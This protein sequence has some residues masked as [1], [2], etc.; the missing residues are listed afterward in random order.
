M[1]VYPDYYKDFKCINKKC[2][3]NCCIGWEIDIDP[4]TFSFYNSVKGELGQRLKDNID[5]TDQPHFI[6]G[7]NERC[8]FLN[9]S[10]LCDIIT[11]LGEGCI[12]DI[13]RE[14]PRFYNEFGDTTESGLGLCCEEAARIILTKRDKVSLIF[15]GKSGFYD[16]QT[17]IRDRII[18]ILQNREKDIDKRFEEVYEFLNIKA[19]QFQISDWLD[20][21]LRLER[22]DDKWTEI[23]LLLKENTEKVDLIKFENY[24]FDRKT[25]YEQ[26]V[27]YLIYR[28]FLIY[29]GITTVLFADFVYQLIFLIG[30]VFYA[31]DG[32]YSQET[33]IEII[34]M[35]SSEIEYS[36]ENL[37]IIYSK[38]W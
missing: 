15:E 7:A 32:E 31:A 29:D 23:L 38:L 14:H 30:A 19:P 16:N 37:G 3:H 6:L 11:D 2:K 26:L 4:D 13:C 1:I 20:T 35:F 25:E 28:Y 34:R 8:P 21:L 18:S 9:S 36:D 33:Q 5:N 22:L 24:I 10:N 17:K 12:C 27:I